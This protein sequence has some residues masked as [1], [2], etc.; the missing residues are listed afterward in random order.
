LQITSAEQPT[1]LFVQP[2][3]AAACFRH[4]MQGAL[5]M[6][7]FVSQRVGPHWV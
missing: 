2:G 1:S 7:V 3:V 5:G 6:V 4:M